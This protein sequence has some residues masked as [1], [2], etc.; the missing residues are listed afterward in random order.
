MLDNYHYKSNHTIISSY[1]VKS[2]KE[3]VLEFKSEAIHFTYLKQNVIAYTVM[4]CLTTW[5]RS[6][7]CIFR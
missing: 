2:C 5:I 6:E 1:I 3:A 7:K 4:C